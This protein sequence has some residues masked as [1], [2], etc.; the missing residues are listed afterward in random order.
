MKVTEKAKDI[1]F[2][3]SIIKACQSHAGD[4]LNAAKRVL[5]DENLPNIAYHLA[6]LALEEI[7]KSELVGMSYIAKTEKDSALPWAEKQTEDHVKK[8]YWALWGPSF[9]RELLTK[10]QIE[11]YIGLAQS[12]HE[13]RI[14]G[15]Y[16]DTFDKKVL[17]PKDSIEKA[18]AENLINLAYIRLQMA[19]LRKF[20]EFDDERK[21]V[22][23]WFLEAT[24]DEEKRKL[25]M[26]QKSME[27][28]VELG[29]VPDWVTWLK[30]E[31]DQADEEARVQTERELK[32]AKPTKEDAKDEK[33]KMKIRLFSNSH[34]INPKMLHKWNEL[35]TWI[36]LFPVDKKRD[37]LIVQ[38]TL[39][40]AVSVHGLWWTGWGV[41]RKF[42]VALNIG[43]MGFFWWYVPEHIS[44]FY[45]SIKDLDSNMDIHVQRSPILRL[46]WN[47][48]ALS[49]RDLIETALCFGMLTGPQD[50]EQNIIFGSYTEGLAFLS[51]SD[52][53]LQFEA[54]A[55]DGFY[56]CLKSSMQF[57]GDWDGQSP[58]P[59][60]FEQFLATLN[61][62]E[63][64]RKKQ[65]KMGEQFEVFP[66]NTKGIT[67]SGVGSIKI[68]CDAYLIGKFR[69]LGKKRE[70]DK[71]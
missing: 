23:S 9:G 10:D 5:E 67:L 71:S 6:A 49:D 11:S 45:E 50:K 41:A 48:R 52:I 55:Y 31:F 18:E 8:L 25:I 20:E 15:L 16:V 42:T 36:K 37:Q 39:P 3:Q 7:G 68:A 69:E 30:K 33:W 70:K 44:R 13:K 43:S 22:L 60:R 17:Y 66:P 58:F 59:K 32:R 14:R 19:K 24:D 64:E 47:Q 38:F 27:K 65:M 62:R 53:H 34:S 26:G 51:K 35:Q 2:L 46:D 4:L 21:D 56:K 12:I 61:I 54:N 63:E 40:K 57:Y 28:L 1:E 29:N